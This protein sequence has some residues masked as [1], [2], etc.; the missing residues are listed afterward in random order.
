M[1]RT[2]KFALPAIV[3]VLAMPV[4]AQDPANNARVYRDGN[5]WVEEI[6]GTIAAP[7]TLK[8]TTDMGSINVE[9]GTQKDATYTVRKRVYSGSEEA[10]RRD[11]TGFRV[12]ASKRGDAAVLEGTTERRYGRLSVEFR[13]QVPRDLQQ[14]RVNTEGGSLSLRNLSGQVTAQ[15]GGGSI[16]L[17]D[18]GGPTAA[19]TGGG[20]I[21]V[22]NSSNVLNVNTGGGSRPDR[23]RQGTLD[24]GQRS[25][26]RWFD[27]TAFTS[28][29]PYTYGNAGRNILFGPGR[30]NFD[31]SLFKDFPIHER[32][33]AQFRAEAFN[34]FNTPQFGLPNASIG[35]AQA[36]VISS[37]IGNPRQMQLALRVQF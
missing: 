5:S 28:P 29:P 14:V 18:I 36:G 6:T 7:A 3:V 16:S 22:G 35:S 10:A 25:L 13:V 4:F 27:T 21:E 37:T 20:S 11:L 9:G 32:L 12:T 17:E 2:L 24:S 15:S 23:L 33:K 1:K 26:Q 31:L 19:S 8:V 30:V 34:A